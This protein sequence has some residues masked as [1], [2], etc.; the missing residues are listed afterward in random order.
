[1]ETG[2]EVNH[3][4]SARAGDTG[5]YVSI[6]EK[7]LR[8]LQLCPQGQNSE[9]GS[10][11]QLMLGALHAPGARLWAGSAS[12]PCTSPVAGSLFFPRPAACSRGGGAA[13]DFGNTSGCGF[14]GRAVAKQLAGRSS[15]VAGAP[16]DEVEPC[17]QHS[18]GLYSLAIICLGPA[19]MGPCGLHPTE[20]QTFFTLNTREV[21][22]DRVCFVCLCMQRC[23]W[24]CSGSSSLK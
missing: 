20:T 19:G 6:A 22:A 8:G 5:G 3:R 15:E 12:L 23:A 24:R 14:S 2:P 16:D 9:L 4:G 7:R 13:L 18:E 11:T 1:M 17:A 10:F 21:R